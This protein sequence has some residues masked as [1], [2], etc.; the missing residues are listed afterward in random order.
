M[1]AK[2]FCL[3]IK[4]KIFSTHY[5]Y[6]EGRIEVR[7]GLYSAIFGESIWELLEYSAFFH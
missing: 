2:L 3:I 5:I 4:K 1:N 6:I 7:V